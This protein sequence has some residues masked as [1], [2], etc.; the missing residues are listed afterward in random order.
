MRGFTLVEVL[1]VMAIVAILA[2]LVVPRFAGERE[3]AFIA[4][5]K[6]DLKNLG[7]AEETYYRTEGT[8]GYTT[9]KADLNLVESPGVTIT[10]VEASSAGWSARATHTGTT[11]TCAYYYGDATPVAPATTAGVPECARP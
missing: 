4:T 9:N 7:T 8:Y 1:V 5:M 6:A 3:R 11:W 2:A 10:I